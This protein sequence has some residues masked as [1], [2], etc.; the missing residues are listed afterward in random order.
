MPWLQSNL[1]A[2]QVDH[3]FDVVESGRENGRRSNF[4]ITPLGVLVDLYVEVGERLYSAFIDMLLE[5]PHTNT[6]KAVLRQ[7]KSSRRLDIIRRIVS[8]TQWTTWN[9]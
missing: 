4:W 5:H 1:L 9:S 8:T 6:D 2:Y 3:I 7:L